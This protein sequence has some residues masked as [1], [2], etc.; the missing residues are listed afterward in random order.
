MARGNNVV[1]EH[2]DITNYVVCVANYFNSALGSVLV[3]V[4]QLGSLAHG[5]FSKIYSDIDVGLLLNS[6]QPPGRISEL[7]AVAVRNTRTIFPVARMAYHKA[8][9]GSHQLN[10]F[11]RD[12]VQRIAA[13]IADWATSTG[14]VPPTPLTAAIHC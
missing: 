11:T 5:G 4:Y 14:W 3:E 13:N 7:I 10:S 12:E 6:G 8:G 1:N 2:S 9:S